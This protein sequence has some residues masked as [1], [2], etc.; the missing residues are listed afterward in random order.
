M[1]ET[2]SWTEDRAG[3]GV[4]S[5]P[6]AD[7]GR[8]PVTPASDPPPVRLPRSFWISAANRFSG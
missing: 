4:R 2:C 5:K 3:T 6:E 7:P 1:G 8:V